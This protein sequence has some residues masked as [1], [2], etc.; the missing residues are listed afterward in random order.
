MLAVLLTYIKGRT[1]VDIVTVTIGKQG[2]GRFDAVL[3]P[4]DVVLTPFDV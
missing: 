3:T 2:S 1:Q 4:F